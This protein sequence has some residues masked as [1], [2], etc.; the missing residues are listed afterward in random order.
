M[1]AP[2]IEKNVPLPPKNNGH[3]DTSPRSLMSKMEVGDSILFE[4]P[5]SKYAVLHSS[6]K[7]AGIK[8]TVRFVEGGIRVWRIE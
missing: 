7:R 4:V 6:A 2:A 3:V 5:R 8:I 1:N